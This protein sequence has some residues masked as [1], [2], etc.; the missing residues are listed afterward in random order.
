MNWKIIFLLPCFTVLV[1]AGACNQ[2]SRTYSPEQT[3]ESS[4]MDDNT[5]EYSRLDNNPENL[6]PNASIQGWLG[7]LEKM[8]NINWS[9]SSYIPTTEEKDNVKAGLINS[10][11]PPDILEGLLVNS[12]QITWPP[13]RYT[14][15]AGNRSLLKSYTL[16]KI[17]NITAVVVAAFENDSVP[18]PGLLLIFKRLNLQIVNTD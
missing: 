11:C 5:G 4:Q 3:G 10:G 12:Q 18:E 1:N 9:T 16:R 14:T 7:P 13:D 6:H 15:N 17:P 8:T 2:P